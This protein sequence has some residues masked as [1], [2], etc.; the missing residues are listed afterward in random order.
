[1]LA[2]ALVRDQPGIAHHEHLVPLQHDRDEDAANR[3]VLGVAQGFRR[4]D[5]LDPD[6]RHLRPGDVELD[7]GQQ[8]ILLL[9]HRR[10]RQ[11]RVLANF[12]D[13]DDKAQQDT[14]IRGKGQ[15]AI[16]PLQRGWVRRSGWHCRGSRGGR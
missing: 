4:T 12:H 7:L 14:D 5:R 3:L 11:S 1:M 6:D 2:H 10:A 8:I 9:V 15:P 13:Q 16:E